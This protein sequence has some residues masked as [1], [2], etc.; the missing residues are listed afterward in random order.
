MSVNSGRLI[1]FHCKTYS[2]T[3]TML[4]IKEKTARIN[5]RNE[6]DGGNLPFD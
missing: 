4:A 6:I 5:T 2:Q 3:Q 1:V